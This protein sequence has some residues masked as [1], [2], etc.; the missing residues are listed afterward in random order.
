MDGGC[1]DSFVIPFFGPEESRS[2]GLTR[3]SNLHLFDNLHLLR[4]HYGKTLHD[5]SSLRVWSLAV[6]FYFHG[7]IAKDPKIRKR[8]ASCFGV[9]E[10]R[11]GMVYDGTDDGRDSTDVDDS[12][13]IDANRSS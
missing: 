8:L 1:Y 12:S 5:C 13:Y 9:S 7:R 6:P 11:Q 4:Y 3:S 2:S 10:W